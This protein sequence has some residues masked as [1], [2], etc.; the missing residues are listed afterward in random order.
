M[1]I[2]SAELFIS[3]SSAQHIPDAIE[4]KVGSIPRAHQQMTNSMNSGLLFS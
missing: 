1:G 3:G 2:V 4:A